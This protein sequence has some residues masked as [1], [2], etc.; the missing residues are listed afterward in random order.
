MPIGFD[1]SVSAEK[2]FY[3]GMIGDKRGISLNLDPLQSR[4]LGSI[5]YAYSEQA[6]LSLEILSNE[7]NYLL[8]Q[9]YGYSREKGIT[10]PTGRFHAEQSDQESHINGQWVSTDGKK[11]YPVHLEREALIHELKSETNGQVRI[12]FVAFESLGLKDL[13]ATL[14]KEAHLELQEGR[15]RLQDD[16]G[17]LTESGIGDD[18]VKSRFINRDADVEYLSPR[19]VSLSY[20]R[21]EFL[22]GAHPNTTIKGESYAI[23][24]EGRPTKITLKD[25][26]ELSPKNIKFLSS[27]L[28][29]DLRQQKAGF[30]KSGDVKG[31][32]SALSDDKLSF[33]LMPSGIAFLFSA[34]EVGPYFEGAYRTILPN[35]VLRTLTKANSPLEPRLDEVSRP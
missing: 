31:F 16:E 14:Q 25:L 9:E 19:L 27:L 11:K 18:R 20:V 34:Y 7:N 1:G 35:K 13:N 3:A 10:Q 22:G 29:R 21:S 4:A 30:V 2:A 26:L 24:E 12:S 32:E 15:Q 8:I 28:I 23:D 33:V 5:H 6:G 17:S